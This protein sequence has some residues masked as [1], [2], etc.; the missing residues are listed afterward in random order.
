MAS[1]WPGTPVLRASPL[2]FPF[3]G[4]TTTRLGFPGVSDEEPDHSRLR[5]RERLA[6]LLARSPSELAWLTQVHGAEV[7]RAESGGWQ[8]EG[9]ALVSADPGRVLLVS[10]ADCC[11]VL[12]WDAVSGVFGIAHAG[13]RGLVA[14]VLG[15]TVEALVDLGARASDVQAWIGPAIGPCCFEVGPD[16]AQHFDARCVRPPGQA[17]RTRPHVDL[18]L[19]CRSGLESAGLSPERV[20]T[21]ADCTSCRDDLYWSYRRDGGICGRQLGFIHR[22]G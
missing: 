20:G 22:T 12:L 2:T 21:A 17:G 6:A 10:V 13:W 4:G 3:D 9:D 1:A 19:A 16:V 18:R 5:A 11:P 8:G 15:A 14:G 7:R